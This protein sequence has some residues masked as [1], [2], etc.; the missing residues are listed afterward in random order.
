M[1]FFMLFCFIIFDKSIKAFEHNAG[2][3]AE[4]GDK[5]K[6]ERKGQIFL[7][8]GERPKGEVRME[9]KI[10]NQISAGENKK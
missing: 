7:G 2:E 10:S 3:A 8:I 1:I 4:K 5:S 9:N 6:D